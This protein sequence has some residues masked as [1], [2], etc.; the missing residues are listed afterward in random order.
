MSAKMLIGI[1]QSGNV[2]STMQ[3]LWSVVD[4]TFTAEPNT[5]ITT[6]NAARYAG[7]ITNDGMYLATAGTNDGTYSVLIHKRTSD[8]VFTRLVYSTAITAQTAYANTV[9]WSATGTY[10]AFSSGSTLYIVKRTADTTYTNV[11]TETVGSGGA[12]NGVHFNGDDYVAVSKL[13]GGDPNP[14]FIFKRTEGTDTFA[15]IAPPTN[16]SNG[17][18][19][20]SVRF[21]PDGVY[22]LC[23]YQSSATVAQQTRLFKRS[24]DTFTSLGHI[25]TTAGNNIQAVDFAPNADYLAVCHGSSAALFKRSGDVFTQVSSVATTT[26]SCSARF[27]GDGLHIAIAQSTSNGYF[28]I[29]KRTVDAISTI[30][31]LSSENS[32]SFIPKA[33]IFWPKAESNVVFRALSGHV[34]DSAGNPISRKV[35]IYHRLSGNMVVEVTS[36]PTTGAWGADSYN[37][38]EHYVMVL[39]D[40][41]NAMIYD[42]ITPTSSTP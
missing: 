37:R 1:S 39:D 9:S 28:Q 40:T 25:V 35:R 15:T 20:Y 26:D 7:D 5:A 24:G 36:D 30:Y 10:L 18:Y 29:C 12:I 8:T 41:K 17:Q 27:S 42:H 23:G 31:S 4:D 16:P 21:S 19:A 32:A 38:T 14:I 33:A 34:Y 3:R 11:L 22:L 2:T 6:A 13:N